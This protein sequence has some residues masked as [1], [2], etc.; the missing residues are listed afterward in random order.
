[1]IAETYV[2]DQEWYDEQHYPYAEL[3]SDGYEYDQYGQQQ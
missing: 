1:V 3:L 2:E